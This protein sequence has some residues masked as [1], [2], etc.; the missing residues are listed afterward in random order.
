MDPTRHYLLQWSR[1]EK[2]RRPLGGVGGGRTGAA[3]VAG[4]GRRRRPTAGGGRPAASGRRR[5]AGCEW[6]VA[7]RGKRKNRFGDFSFLGKICSETPKNY[8]IVYD[9]L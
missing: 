3:T 1:R 9:T 2:G 7:A 6:E 5:A 4:L 8:V